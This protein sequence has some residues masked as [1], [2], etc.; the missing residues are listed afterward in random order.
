LSYA[1][2][3][4]THHPDYLNQSDLAN[5]YPLELDALAGDPFGL[6]PQPE[7]ILRRHRRLLNAGIEMLRDPG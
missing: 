6:I 7:E 4:E 5:I 3:A 1:L 2:I